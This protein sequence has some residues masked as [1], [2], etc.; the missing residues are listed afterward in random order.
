MSYRVKR[1]KITQSIKINQKQFIKLRLIPWVRTMNGCVWLVSMAVCRS[2][3]QANDW[4]QERKNQ[5]TRQLK[6]NMTGKE[7]SRLQIMS[8]KVLRKWIDLIP[9]GDSV[10]FRCN[11]AKKEKQFR[12]WKKWF[13]KRENCNWIIEEDMKIF[14]YYKPLPIE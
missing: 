7:A 4:M 9:P 10:A 12:I 2:K 14:F 3:R 11:S 1:R 5:R 6:L 8:M 13:L